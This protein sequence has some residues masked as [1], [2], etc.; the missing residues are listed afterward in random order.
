MTQAK[1]ERFGYNTPLTVLL[2][3]ELLD[4]SPGG[5]CLLHVGIYKRSY[6]RSLLSFALFFFH[7]LL[8]LPRISRPLNCT[9]Y[10]RIFNVEVSWF[11]ALYTCVMLHIVVV[12]MK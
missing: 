9:H 11:P 5:S 3:P 2:I 1:S 12:V 8:Y 7:F 10:P 6:A 4:I